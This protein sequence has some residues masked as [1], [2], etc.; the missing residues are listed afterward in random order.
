MTGG[1]IVGATHFDYEK[2]TLAI[3]GFKFTYGLKW[4]SIHGKGSY[5]MDGLFGGILPVFGNGDFE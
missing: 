3:A 1:E 4:P 5:G 2:L